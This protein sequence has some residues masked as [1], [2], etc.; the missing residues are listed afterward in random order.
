M[1]EKP[2]PSD[3]AELFVAMVVR[4]VRNGVINSMRT[5]LERHLTDV[6]Y[7]DLPEW[8]LRLR[9]EEKAMVLRVVQ[10]AVDGTLLSFM[11]FLQEEPPHLYMESAPPGVFSE[12]AVYLQVYEDEEAYDVERPSYQARVDAH[13]EGE[14]VYE[15]YLGALIEEEEGKESE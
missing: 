8:F 7:A 3:P 5:M 12:F 4:Q 15:R 6:P 11:R 2:Y 13:T 10:E 9:D 14:G 1:M